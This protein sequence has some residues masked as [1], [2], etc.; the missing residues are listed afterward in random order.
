M[1]NDPSPETGSK[2]ADAGEA[3]S[4][5][6]P[7]SPPAISLPKG[8]GAIRGI[9]EACRKMGVSVMRCLNNGAYPGAKSTFS[10]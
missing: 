4:Q 6:T 1:L 9:G 8:G 10:T 2:P 5:Q 7:F 3:T